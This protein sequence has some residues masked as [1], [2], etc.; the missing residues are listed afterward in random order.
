MKKWYRIF[1]L[2]SALALTA[3]VTADAQFPQYGSCYTYCDGQRYDLGY[4]TYGQCCFNLN[5]FSSS[6]YSVGWEWTPYGEGDS[7]VC[8]G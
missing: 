5:H 1:G 3:V 2:A 7:L 4:I 8:G 6:C